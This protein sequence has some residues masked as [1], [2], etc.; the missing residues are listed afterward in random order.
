MTA[1]PSAADLVIVGAGSAGSVIA[2][3]VS[4]RGDRSVVLLE[5]GPDYPDPAALPAD[6]AD[7]SRNSIRAHDWRYV[8]RPRPEQ[9]WMKFVYPRGRVVGGSSAVNTCI[10]LRGQPEDYDQWAARGL[11]DWS[12]EQ[13]LPAFV[14]LERDLDFGGPW[15]GREGPLPIRRH[16]REELVPWQAAFLEACAEI[17][18]PQVEDLNDPN[19]SGAAPH[20]M[21]KIDGRRISAAEAWLTPAVRGRPNLRIVPRTLVRRLLFSRGR[22][23]GVEVEQDGA[24]AVIE[25]SKVVLSAGALNTP[26]IL[27]RSGVGPS[28]ELA[29]LGVDRVAEVPA[30]GAQLLDHPGTAIFLRPQ[31]QVLVKR[32]P[33][34]QV[35]LRYRSKDGAMPNDM[36]LQPGSIFAVPWG[37]IPWVSLMCHVGK[38]RGSGRLVWPSADPHAKPIIESHLFREAEDREKAAEAMAIAAALAA[39]KTLSA[40]ARP[41]APG[42]R[43][44]SDPKR[45]LRWCA[46]RCDSG[47]HPSGTVPMGSDEDRGA[48]CDGRGRVRGVEG[49][50]VA[51]ASLM[52]T[53]P[54]SNIHLAVLMIG[55]RIGGWLRDER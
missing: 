26:G 35:G 14:R 47:Y 25:S 19:Q 24:L 55:E 43:T 23:R 21:N 4:E 2:S 51:D 46:T 13:C 20:P 1:L 37:D 48:A 45:L 12:W 34:I 54:S 44:L 28:P 53:V 31:K 29:R 27:L 8:H 50:I 42:W 32:P 38:P 15:H 39:S 40:L 7:G 17:G 41:I 10:A 5:A 36:L 11:P 16:R 30:V 6:L 18:L 49:L 52:P 9:W 33:L 22:V 3:R